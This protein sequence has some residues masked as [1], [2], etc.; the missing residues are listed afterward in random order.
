MSS[1]LKGTS[2]PL[3][4]KQLIAHYK[5]NSETIYTPSKCN[6]KVTTMI[7]SLIGTE[8]SFLDFISTLIPPAVSPPLPTAFCFLSFP[9][10]SCFPLWFPTKCGK[11]VANALKKLTAH[12]LFR[13]S[14]ESQL[15]S[16]LPPDVNVSAFYS[17]PFQRVSE[18]S[19]WQHVFGS[20]NY[21]SW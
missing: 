10:T 4:F 8:A 1:N 15:W 16:N 9:K 18:V 20:S 6:G 14:G 11:M 5:A 12:H 13:G 19:I 7:F 2:T 21:K 17:V 3:H